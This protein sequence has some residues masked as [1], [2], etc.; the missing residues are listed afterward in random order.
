MISTSAG[1]RPTSRAVLAQH[2]DLA[3]QRRRVGRQVAA[4]GLLGDD[5]QGPPLARSADDDRHRPDRPG[6]AGGLRQAGRTGRGKALV[7]G[8]QSARSVS[9]QTCSWSSRSLAAGK[10]SPYAW[11]S[12]NHQPAPSPQNAR[13]L[14]SASRVATVLAMMPGV[15]EGH[16]R[17]QRAEPQ[18]GVQAGEQAQRHPGLR[19]RFPGPVRPAGSGSGGP[20]GRCRRSPSPSA[21]PGQLDQPA[22]R[23][24]APR[25]PGHLQDHLGAIRSAV[26]GWIDGHRP[27]GHRRRGRLVVPGSSMI[28]TWSQPSSAA[29]RD[30]VTQPGAAAR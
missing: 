23:V 25:E 11:C 1:S 20:S 27:G 8:A 7:P 21:A 12:R 17:D 9:M 6:I 3:R 2:V 18:P 22:A 4:V 19:D 26:A 24:L 29:V 15:A 30:Q 14:L 13:P 5:P 16:R 28:T 10:S